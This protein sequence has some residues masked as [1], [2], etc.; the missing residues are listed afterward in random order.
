LKTLP[1]LTSIL[2]QRER[3]RDLK[4][5]SSFFSFWEK[6]GMRAVKRGME[7]F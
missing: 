4:R 7:S 2:S 5:L 1:A 6:A 3:K